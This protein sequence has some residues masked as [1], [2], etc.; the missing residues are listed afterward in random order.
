[1]KKKIVESG[2]S[3][4]QLVYFAWASASTYRNSDRRGGANGARIRLYPINEWEVNHPGEL[5]KVLKI[6]EK[7]KEEFDEEQ[8][9]KG[10]RKRISIAD[11]IVLG[12]C[13]AV[14]EAA[15][16]AGFSISVPFIA[17]RVDA[18]EE[19]MDVE[20]YK[21]LEPFADGFR[22]YFRY[23][24]RINEGDI[25]TTPEY[26]LVD[27]AQLLNLNVQELVVFIGGMRSLG[28]NYRY[29]DLGVLTRNKG[30]LS[31]EFFE[32]LLSMDI[33]WQ[34]ADK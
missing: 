25:Y 10:S 11:L 9:R 18:G 3:I 1:L 12:G 6:Y 29:T 7:I 17:G 32:N 21:I 20:F 26:F 31:N 22:N 14:E 5:K 27:K 33:E 4:S 30:V 23:P 2:L 19:H 13:C 8:R 16:R 15:R 24:E 34:A 28:A